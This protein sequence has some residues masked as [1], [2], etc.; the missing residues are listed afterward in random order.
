[1]YSINGDIIS[2]QYGNSLAH[3]HKLKEYPLPTN[4][5]FLTSF[6]RHFKNNMND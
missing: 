3:K 1:M 2:L 5:E 6:R 4:F